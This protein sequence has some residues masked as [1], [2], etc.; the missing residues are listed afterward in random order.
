MEKYLKNVLFTSFII[1]VYQGIA[2][3]D[4][5]IVSQFTHQKDNDWAGP[6]IT[7]LLFLGSGIGSMYNKYVKKYQ[8]RYCF[9]FGS[10]G[11]II[12][13][14]LGLIFIKIGFSI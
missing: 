12:F 13:I 10:F 1:L 4:L 3:S 11:Y 5:G 2:N 14:S 9:L 7:S 8:Y 6:L